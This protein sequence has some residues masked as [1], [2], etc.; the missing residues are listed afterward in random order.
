ML[1][2]FGKDGKIEHVNQGIGLGI[3][4]HND[5]MLKYGYSRKT[6]LEATIPAGQ[7][8]VIRVVLPSNI[9]H[10]AE[11][12]ILET[13][14]TS[15]RYRVYKDVV[16]ANFPAQVSL[17]PI[18]NE[19]GADL[20]TLSTTGSVFSYHGVSVNNPIVSGT[21]IDNYPVWVLEGAG[22]RAGSPEA[23]QS[24]GGRYYYPSTYAVVIQNI[25]TISTQI[26]YQYEWHEF[27]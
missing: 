21:L 26:Y 3:M 5:V 9:N 18:L 16:N 17:M 14:G 20:I 15:I 25:G 4:N 19:R 7:F 27:Y 2:V 12:R 6:Y 24:V 1:T 13:F 10:H 22:N 8:L 11:G 23:S